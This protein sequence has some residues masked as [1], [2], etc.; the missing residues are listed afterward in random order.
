MRMRICKTVPQVQ[1]AYE[2]Q[3]ELFF[4]GAVVGE[5]GGYPST[6]VSTLNLDGSFFIQILS[7]SALLQP[8]RVW[9]RRVCQYACVPDW[10]APQ[11]CCTFYGT[12]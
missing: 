7:I 8:S 11:R 3:R 6:V 10:C 2:V 12:R 4:S 5:G 1:E 9:S